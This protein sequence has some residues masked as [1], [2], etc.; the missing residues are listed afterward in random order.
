MFISQEYHEDWSFIKRIW[1]KFIVSYFSLYI[2]LTFLSS[3]FEIPFR[4][5]GDIFLG[6]NYD[7]DVSGYGSGD[8]TYAYVTLFGNL[9]L[10]LICTIIWQAI[11]NKRKSYNKAFYWFTVFVR[12]YLVF[13]MFTYGFVKVFQ[14]QF[15][16]PDLRR[17]L[18]PLGEFSPM[19]LAWTYMGY[20]KGFNIFAGG[21]EVLGGLLLIPRRT[22]TLGALVTV[23]V[24]LQV[25][26][27]NF[28]FDIPVK[29]FS[30]HLI[31][32][33]AILFT[34]DLKRLF[35]VFGKNKSETSYS[36]YHPVDEPFYHKVIAGFKIVACLVLAG[37]MM[38]QG[39]K[40]EKTWGPKRELPPMYGIWEAN[41]FVKNGDTLAPLMNDIERWRYLLIDYK[42]RATI[43]LMDNTEIRCSFLLDS[44]LNSVSIYE[45]GYDTLTNNFKYYNPNKEFLELNGSLNTI[46][47]LKIIFSR[48]NPDSML[49][50]KRGFRWINERPYNR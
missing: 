39:I 46:D 49:L 4:W 35:A 16:P 23:G 27:M 7:Y 5:L 40:R 25:A 36:R 50:R 21:M 11:D 37:L 2:L 30:V 12:V 13:F 43:K 1:F 24:M 33:A 29:L 10:A 9:L 3:L 42:D 28:F 6:I 15:P 47:S 17:L 32:L 48:I 31:L 41:I 44:T 26:M 18:Q 14:T 20:S 38:N 34:A 22:Q 19:G 8:N 45:R